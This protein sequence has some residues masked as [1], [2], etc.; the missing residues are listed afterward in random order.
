MMACARTT[1]V[2]ALAAAVLAAC[3]TSA[4]A[5]TSLHPR[6]AESKLQAI[7]QRARAGTRYVQ[8]GAGTINGFRQLVSR[9]NTVE[10]AISFFPGWMPATFACLNSEAK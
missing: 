9:G 1:A 6:A 4:C 10:A 8:F 2:G 3:A 7:A 5:D